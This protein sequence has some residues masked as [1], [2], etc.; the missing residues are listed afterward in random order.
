MKSILR[1]V[2]G[3]KNFALV[4]ILVAII[5]FFQVISGATYLTKVNIR[6]ILNHTAVV[7]L[8]SIGAGFLI[9]SGY[10]DLSAG[11]VGTLC[12]MLVA[13]LIVNRG[14]P[15]YL[16]FLITLVLA[17]IVGVINATLVHKLGFQAFIATIAMG[18]VCEGLSYAISAGRT[19]TIKN[20]AFNSIG[21]S[22]ILNIVPSSVIFAVVALI[23]YGLILSKTKFG[24]K[25]FIIGGN[26]QAARLTGL[27]PVKISYILFV[28]NAAL[29]CI[30]G[31]LVASRIKGGSIAGI[32]SQNFAGITAAILGGI[33]F[34]G[35][36][37][38][39]TGIT[40]GLLIISSFNNGLTVMRVESQ[41]SQ[42]A[43]GALLVIALVVDYFLSAKPKLKRRKAP[44][45]GVLKV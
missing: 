7:A 39:V 2:L 28:N 1:R 37:G 5:V 42:V 24:R 31:C 38:S 15:W 43:S 30:A 18:S 3:H 14:V 35:G 26:P 17:M 33:S 34:S 32:T 8:L 23:V 16:A 20:A 6:N 4:L 36:T 9:I 41:W 13:D 25:M 40:I 44:K 10:I 19:I 12:G 29:S 21:T 27:N 22:R 45:A 11:Y